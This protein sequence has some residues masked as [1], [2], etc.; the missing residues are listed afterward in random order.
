MR[1]LKAPV[2]IPARHRSEDDIVTEVFFSPLRGYWINQND[3][4]QRLWRASKDAYETKADAALALAFNLVRWEQWTVTAVG[5]LAP[6]DA[7]KS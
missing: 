4:R 5:P 3:L 6:A 7:A 2:K 1:T